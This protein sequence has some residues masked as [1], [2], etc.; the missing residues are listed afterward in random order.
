MTLIEVLIVVVIMAILASIIIPH[1]VESTDEAKMSVAASNL[2]ELRKQI[3]LFKVHHGG[4]PPGAGLAELTQAT[5]HRGQ[6]FAPYITVLPENPISGSNA[7]KAPGGATIVIGDV[8]AAPGGG[9][10]YS[11]STGEIRIDHP[12]HWQK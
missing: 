3:E 12:D 8:T 6:T 4:T 2:N 7:V 1:F 5:T 11:A 9:W 10:I